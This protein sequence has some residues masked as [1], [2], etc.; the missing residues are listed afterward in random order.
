M[1]A[2]A[3]KFSLWFSKPPLPKREE[4]E[5]LLDSVQRVSL[6]IVSA[7]YG[8]PKEHGESLSSIYLSW[9]EHA[10]SNKVY[11]RLNNILCSRRESKYQTQDP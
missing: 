9:T 11:V 6:V 4:C 5:S 10:N 2:E 1:S 8:L 3:T 7:Y